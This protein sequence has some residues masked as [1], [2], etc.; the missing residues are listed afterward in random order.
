MSVKPFFDKIKQ[1]ML[2]LFLL[3]YDLY[4]EITLGFFQSRY[5]GDLNTVKLVYD[6]ENGY[7]LAIQN[8][9]SL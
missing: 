3:I 6:E 5:A 8:L 1:S 2:A 7:A 9:L 4:F